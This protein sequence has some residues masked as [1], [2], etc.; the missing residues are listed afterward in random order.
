MTRTKRLAR[1]HSPGRGKT[2]SPSHLVGPDAAFPRPDKRGV[3]QQGDGV[4][5]ARGE[6]RPHGAHDDEDHGFTR[7]G[8]AERRLGGDGGEGGDE[9]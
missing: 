3:G 8:H 6:V 4:E 5:G 7:V 2:N 9:S 1:S